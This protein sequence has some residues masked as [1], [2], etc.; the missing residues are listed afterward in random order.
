MRHAFL[1]DESRRR[2]EASEL[3]WPTAISG[4]MG[5]GIENSMTRRIPL[6]VPAD[7]N[8]PATK[9]SSSFNVSKR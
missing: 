5:E 9:R 7:H 1:F 6:E 3:L 8:L 4:Q 2:W